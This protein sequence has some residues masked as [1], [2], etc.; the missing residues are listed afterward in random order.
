MEYLEALRVD[1]LLAVEQRERFMIDVDI[2]VGASPG[3][4]PRRLC[5]STDE[6][7]AR[8]VS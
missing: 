6:T 1:V 5:E 3:H 2:A 8:L 7:T 4:Q